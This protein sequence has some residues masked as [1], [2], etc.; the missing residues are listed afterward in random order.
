LSPL[1]I[2]FHP[3]APVERQNREEKL[4][5]NPIVHVEVLGEDAEVLQGFYRD[6]FEW[7]MRP[8]GP[9]YAMAHPGVE[10]GIDGGVGASPEGDRG[11][12]TFYVEVGDLEVTL[13]KIEGLGGSR[14]AGPMDVPGGPRIAMFADPEGHVVGLIEAVSRRS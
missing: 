8:S 11:H 4:M 14:V 10:G 6:A 13:G 3:T 5:S 12:V 2:R 9:D 1:S 7:Q